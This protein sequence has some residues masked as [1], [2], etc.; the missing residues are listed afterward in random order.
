MVGNG[1]LIEG[2]AIALK[3]RRGLYR[4]RPDSQSLTVQILDPP[5]RFNITDLTE[6]P[7]GGGEIGV[8]QDDLAD[9]LHWNP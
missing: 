2:M 8:P 5:H 6:I 4:P 3:N 7:L 1:E 9:N